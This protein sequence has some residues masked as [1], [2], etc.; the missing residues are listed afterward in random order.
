MEDITISYASTEDLEQIVQITGDWANFFKD[1]G[2]RQWGVINYSDGTSKS[3]VERYPKEYYQQEIQKGNK[4]L[5]AKDSNGK[6]YAALDL[7][8]VDELWPEESKQNDAYY[9]HH[10]VS[11]R[12]VDSK[13]ATLD[14]LQAAANVAMQDGRNNIRLDCSFA[15]PKLVSIY[16]DKYGFNLLETGVRSTTG[17]NY[18][19]FE[20]RADILYRRI[21]ELKNMSIENQSKAM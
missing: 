16:K 5:V 9:I 7:K 13:R 12:N 6:V 15:N 20:Q 4:I 11:D 1:N 14:L 10:F 18:A 21:E 8:L 3:Y 2:I 17:Y 19:K